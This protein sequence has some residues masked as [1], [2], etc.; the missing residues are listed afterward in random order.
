MDL[1][2]KVSIYYVDVIRLRDEILINLDIRVFVKH[3]VD[4]LIL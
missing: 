2:Y 1:A 3:V 4:L